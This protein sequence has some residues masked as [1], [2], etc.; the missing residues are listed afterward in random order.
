MAYVK[1]CLLCGDMHNPH[2]DCPNINNRITEEL[3]EKIEQESFKIY[4]EKLKK[5]YGDDFKK[6]IR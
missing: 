1:R 3:Q 6:W 4:Y 5:I 2:L